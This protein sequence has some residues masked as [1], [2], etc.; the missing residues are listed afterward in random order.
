MSGTAGQIFFLQKVK[1]ST[2]CSARSIRHTI[3]SPIEYGPIFVLV[4]L[5]FFQIFKA[6]GSIFNSCLNEKYIEKLLRWLIFQD[7]RKN[8]SCGYK[9][10][11]KIWRR[12]YWNKV[13]FLNQKFSI[14][15]LWSLHSHEIVTHFRL[16]T[17][18]TDDGTVF[19]RILEMELPQLSDPMWVPPFGLTILSWL[20]LALK[21]NHL[22]FILCRTRKCSCLIIFE[23]RSSKKSCG[24]P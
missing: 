21:S 14:D 5:Y 1:T 24:N 19:S 9:N 10:K 6:F 17:K 3:M 7:T 4:L 11:T 2:V 23:K 13:L 16:K 20:F 12:W 8:T 18:R 15:G 22:G